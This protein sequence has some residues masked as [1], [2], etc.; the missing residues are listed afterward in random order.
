MAVLNIKRAAALEGDGARAPRQT[1]IILGENALGAPFSTT[2]A[3]ITEVL[4]V[5]AFGA[6]GDGV[7]DDT[8]AIQATYDAIPPFGA[9]VFFPPGV[10]QVSDDLVLPKFGINFVR[11]DISGYG[12]RIRTGEA[13]NVL[14]NPVPTD[15][16]D[17]LSSVNVIYSIRGLVIEGAPTTLTGIKIHATFGLSLV[18]V[19][20]QNCIVG[21]D[22][23][24]CL[25]ANLQNCYATNNEQK[26]FV[27]RTGV[28]E[29]AGASGSNSQS[30][31]TTFESCRS[32]ARLGQVSQ[33]EINSCSGCALRNCITEGNNPADAI[34]MDDAGTTVVKTFFIENHHA[35]NTPTNS[36]FK[37]RMVAGAVFVNQFFVQIGEA[38]LV[39]ASGTSTSVSVN[40]LSVPFLPPGIKIKAG[41]SN[42]PRWYFYGRGQTDID[43][44]DPSN[45]EG[46]VVGAYVEFINNALSGSGVLTSVNNLIT[47]NNIT[48]DSSNNRIHLRG[49]LYTDKAVAATSPGSIIR[50]ISVFDSDTNGFI[51]YLP[52]YDTI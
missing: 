38:L 45:W 7:A 34:V 6:V 12:A 19:E 32:F 13:I 35:E 28:G 43:L 49:N 50:R 46:G 25:N 20:V 37:L 41:S 8:A 40:Y 4:N 42:A 30:N 22:L 21:Y 10:Y 23:L 15:N 14:T 1:D 51:G 36:Y 44:A 31:H 9:H 33:F 18:D 52:V 26:S 11:V 27:A 5:K 3:Q 39:D 24:F 16:S 29:W 48:I 2:V 47:G 17:A